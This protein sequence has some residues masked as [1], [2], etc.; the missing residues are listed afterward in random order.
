M[1][2]LR[3]EL[4]GKFHVA[5]GNTP[6]ASINTNRLR[7]L[8]AYLVLNGDVPQSREHLAFLLW[9]ESEES[10]ARTNLRQLLHHL[11]RAL[12]DADEFVA[13]DTQTVRWKSGADVSFDVA[14][15]EAAMS[16][17]EQARKDRNASPEREALE[18]AARI[19]QDDLASDLYDEWL[20]SPRD[21][22][23]KRLEEGLSRLVALLD[24]SGEIP[25]RSVLR[26]GWWRWS[27]CE[28]SII[29]ASCVCTRSIKTARPRFVFTTNA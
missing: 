18:E 9:P 5:R 1:T 16:R 2:P 15:F 22:L 27:L 23:R 25:S 4:L 13:S 10:Q 20:R 14:E 19:Y 3:I 8:L 12:P 28:K 21:R 26:S 17:A 11:R 24:A 7:S 29:T 6:V